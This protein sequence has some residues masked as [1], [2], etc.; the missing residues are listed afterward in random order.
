VV[1]LDR[2]PGVTG[3][4]TLLEAGRPAVGFTRAGAGEP[5]VLIHPL[6]ADRRMWDPVLDRLA[7]ERDVIAVDLPGFGDSPPIAPARP[8]D[9]AAA[10]AGLLGSLGVE[11]PHVAGNSLGGWVALELALAGEARDVTAIAPAGLW[12]EPLMPKRATARAV[13]RTL[14]PL[15]P[16][17]LRAQAGRRLALS[18]SVAHPERVPYADALRLIRAY[19]SSPGFHAVNA[20]MRAAR[21]AELAEI[22]VPVTLAWPDEDRIV[23]RPRS[24][25]GNVRSVV[26]HGC[27]H[28]PTW[29]DPEQVARLLLGVP[30][31]R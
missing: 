12:S 7:A 8:I 18:A 27:G 16:L 24:L 31:R 30:A 20:A 19:A 6:G 4:V 10:V 13:A 5:L 3:R 28:L 1:A 22:T 15:L 9:L 29:D 2:I 23:G 21:F 17:V 14:S 11:R 26:L 25:P